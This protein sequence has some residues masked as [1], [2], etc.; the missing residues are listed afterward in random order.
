MKR[1]CRELKCTLPRSQSEIT[2]YLLYSPNVMLERPNYEDS[3]D[4]IV[5]EDRNKGKRWILGF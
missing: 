4:K 1:T 2:T 3:K 5:T